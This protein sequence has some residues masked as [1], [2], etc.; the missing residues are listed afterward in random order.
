MLAMFPITPLL[1][2]ANLLAFLLHLGHLWHDT[3]PLSCQTFREDLLL[4][5]IVWK[6]LKRIRMPTFN[7][8]NCFNM[9]QVGIVDRFFMLLSFHLDIPVI[10]N[11]TPAKPSQQ[12][13]R[14]A[15]LFNQLFIKAWTWWLVIFH[16]ATC[17]RFA[18]SW[19]TWHTVAPPFSASSGENMCLQARCINKDIWNE[20]HLNQSPCWNYQNVKGYEKS[21]HCQN[22]MLNDGIKRECE[23]A[24][25]KPSQKTM[26]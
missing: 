9:F 13:A 15:N 23:P 11:S 20:A 16:G 25:C 12:L 2:L 3:L 6:G 14:F 24:I 10:P 17:D 5:R 18:D 21:V 26:L 19:A 8:K 4:K 7:A 22:P 1:H